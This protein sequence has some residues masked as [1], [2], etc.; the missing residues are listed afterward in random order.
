MGEVKYITICDEHKESQTPLIWT[1]AFNGYE[2]WCP[3]CF[4]TFGMLDSHIDVPR[5]ES[6]EKKYSFYKD[7]TK[8][9]LNAKATM[10]CCGKNIKGKFVARKDFTRS[11]IT[12][13]K[14]I[15]S[16]FEEAGGG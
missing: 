11:R 1:F 2:Y 6:L 12:R 9:Y 5:T 4:K 7:K 15:I 8:K 13:C 3:F 14:N 10:I 16:H